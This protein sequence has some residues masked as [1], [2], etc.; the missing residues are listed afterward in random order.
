MNIQ[1]LKV[2]LKTVMS[3][4]VKTL[5]VNLKTKL[6]SHFMCE[7]YNKYK[8]AS[9]RVGKKEYVIFNTPV[10]GNIGDHAIIYAEK[11][12]LLESDIEAFEVPTYEE[13]Y[14]FEYIV[15]NISPEATI[16]V[17]GGGFMGSEW[18]VEEELIRKVILNFPYN[19]IIIF[20]QTIYYKEDETGKEK[21]EKSKEIY[22]SHKDLHICAREKVSYDIMKKEYPNVDI[23]LIPDVVLSLKNNN[24]NKF[25]REGILL[26]LRNDKEKNLSQEYTDSILH[27]AKHYFRIVKNSDMV[28]NKNISRRK[29]EKIVL[30]KL[31]EFQKSKLVITDRLHGM[32]FSAI[33]NTP[34]IVLGNY[35]HKIK[36][37]YD[38]I[39]DL[40]YINYV[41]DI[42]E[43]EELVSRYDSYDISFD[44][45][46]F[47][48]KF[49]ELKSILFN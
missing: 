5:L 35:N 20:P 13:K 32:I 46:N 48:N 2:K 1:D 31:D 27:T 15:K 43:V 22:N 17:T 4:R 28:I 11:R 26:V 10:H 23:L 49:E 36:G 29:R 25:I 9:K 16:L 33:T 12:L 38:W 24:N 19:K 44:K 30:E 6:K 47:D 7:D 41:E 39:K 14:C 21:L 18:F 42:S 8:A 37:V 40:D 34:C 3:N 45:S